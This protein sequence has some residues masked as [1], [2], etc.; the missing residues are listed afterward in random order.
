MS[1]TSSQPHKI[2]GTNKDSY[3]NQFFDLS[4]QY[5]PPTIKELFKWCTFYYYNSPLIGSA[6]KKV[7]RYP[8]TDIIYEDGRENIRKIWEHIFDKKLRMKDRCMEINLDYH[9]YGN[10]FISL[11]F[12]FTRFLICLKCKASLPIN[13]I[14]WKFI[15]TKP[16]FLGHC[17]HGQCKSCGHSGEMKVKDVPYKNK[18]GIKIIR[19]NPENITIKYN[20][21]TGRYTYLYQVPRRLMR[22]M[23]R[24]DKDIL[25]DL[26]MIV[27]EAVQKQ[28]RIRLD[29]N[30][31]FHMKNPTLAEQDQGWGKPSI[32]HVLKDMFY[33]YTLRR[34]QEAIALE[35]ILPF[36]VLYPL[37]SAQMDPYMH[38]DLGGWKKKIEEAIKKH[39]K[40]GNYKS[41]MPVPVGHARIGGDGRALMLTP[42]MNYLTQTIVGGMGIV[43]E[44]LFGGLNYSGSSI[45]LRTLENDF[46]QNRSQLLSFLEWT[47]EKIRF[48]L[49]IPDIESMRFADF[50]MADDV[51]RNQQV[52]GLNAQGK[53]SDDTMMTELGFDFEAEQ[54]KLIEEAFFKNYLM[55]IQLK[56]QARSQGESS[57][58]TYN[59]QQKVQEMAEKAQQSAQK[60]ALETLKPKVLSNIGSDSTYVDDLAPS[61]MGAEMDEFGNP[62]AADPEGAVPQEQQFGEASSWQAPQLSRQNSAT[63]EA[64]G[65][66]ETM[67]GANMDPLPKQK[68][69]TRGDQV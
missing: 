61:G 22:A 4:Q 5:M 19:W 18:D 50:R 67:N 52:I 24:G 53:L 42:E 55:D 35:H 20:E 44:F 46:I 34:A 21:Y 45:S 68:A 57:I 8:I 64:M 16:G 39:R 51:Q 33:F 10:A 31:I 13:Q 60:R 49:Q 37:P 7:S 11:H 59:Y 26:P 40:D 29:S 32:I 56:G 28:K 23:E 1:S 65:K 43:Q 63:T 15:G 17:F 69:S 38:T 2:L 9:V 30:A 3:P 66:S 58:V 12:P 27:I 62:I 14:E 6:I 47:K 25:I 36:D 54:K 48:Y 41:V